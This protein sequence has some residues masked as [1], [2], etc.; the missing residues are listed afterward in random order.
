[1]VLRSLPL[2]LQLG[3]GVLM[4]SQVLVLPLPAVLGLHLQK[5]NPL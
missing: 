2:V 1:M 3:L 4:L 5:V